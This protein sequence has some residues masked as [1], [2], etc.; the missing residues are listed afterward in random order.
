MTRTRHIGRRN[1]ARRG[2]SLSE[3]VLALGVLAIG[4]SMAAALFPTAIKL[5]E[6][7]A[8]DAIGTII[9]EN[10]LAV[11]KTMLKN[12]DVP[13]TDPNLIRLA[14]ENKTIPIDL[15]HQHY[16]D[17]TNNA[18]RGFIVLGRKLS[19]ADPNGPVQLVIVSYD[20]RSTSSTVT[21]QS[22][23]ISNGSGTTVTLSGATPPIGSPLILQSTGAYARIIDANG[24]QAILDRAID[25]GDAW[26]IAES[27][28]VARSPAMAVLVADAFLE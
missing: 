24:Q 27:G 5:N 9:A 13:A 22:V 15:N 11:A 3:L 12:S 1:G 4:L 20:K 10:G 25:N 17:S 2:F 21:A 19:A 16:P 26:V 23:T 28:V 14:D 6:Q 8:Q 18:T 7:S